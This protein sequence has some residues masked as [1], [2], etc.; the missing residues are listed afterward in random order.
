M[1]PLPLV[2]C[3]LALGCRPEDDSGGGAEPPDEHTAAAAEHA[4]SG[5]MAEDPHLRLSTL[6]PPAP[7]DSA[8]AA[9]VLAQMRRDLARYR[10]IRVAQADGFRQYIPSGAA[11]VQHFTKLRWALRARTELDPSRPTSLLYRRGNDGKL[12]LVGAMFT[13]PAGVTEDELNR[14]LPLS[15]VRW[16][17]HINWCTPPLRDAR[18]RWRE[19]KDGRPVFGPQSPIATPEAC[20]EVGGRFHRRLLGW[21]VHVMA[22]AG[23]DPEHTH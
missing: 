21:M 19:T 3:A 12:E 6:R 13:A 2:L 18:R 16:H 4:M 22:F 5:A 7:G 1:R 20:A 15:V 9:A 17:Q 8:R 23:D 11:P 10:D 14:R